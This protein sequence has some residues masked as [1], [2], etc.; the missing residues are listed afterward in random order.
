MDLNQFFPMKPSEFEISHKLKVMI[1][2]SAENFRNG[3]VAEK[4]YFPNYWRNR[5]QI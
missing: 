3:Y 5:F 1:K 2:K 4:E